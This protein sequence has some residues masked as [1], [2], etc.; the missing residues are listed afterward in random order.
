MEYNDTSQEPDLQFR[1]TITFNIGTQHR[2]SMLIN[3]HL[4]RSQEHYRILR[5]LHFSYRLPKS[6]EYRLTL[7]KPV[8]M[9]KDNIPDPLFAEVLN[10]ASLRNEMSFYISPM[11]ENAVAIGSLSSPMMVCVF[12]E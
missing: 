9:G 3:G 1:G 7:D 11:G 4:E 6:N 2:G 8:V 10:Q 12:T 5:L